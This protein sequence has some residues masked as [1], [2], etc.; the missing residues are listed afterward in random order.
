MS[1][2]EDNSVPVL[3]TQRAWYSRDVLLLGGLVV[4]YGALVV[5]VAVIAYLLGLRR[6]PPP[7]VCLGLLLALTALVLLLLTAIIYRM[8]R[9]WGQR[10]DSRYR[11]WGLRLFVTAAIIGYLALPFTRLGMPKTRRLT[12]GL[13]RYVEAN[14]DLG[15]VQAWLDTLDPN[16]CSDYVYDLSSGATIESWWPDAAPWARA[17]KPLSPH[18]AILS[19]SSEGRPTIHIFFST[20]GPTDLTVGD[21]DMGIPP[22]GFS[23]HDEYRL[24]VAP[25]A[26]VWHEMH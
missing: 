13:R 12:A 9:R 3:W 25:G 19:L 17:I 24:W 21:P 7:L 26:H 15:A 18:C 22:S 8:V 6:E 10:I 4:A 1:K 2:R 5:A 14:V 23:K 20:G 16:A 11:L